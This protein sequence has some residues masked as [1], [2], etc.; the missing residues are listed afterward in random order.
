[1]SSDTPPS[2]SP[3]SASPAKNVGKVGYG[4]DEP[5]SIIELAIAGGL[6]VVIGFVISA[7][8][9]RINP[10][11]ARIGLLAGPAVGFLILA[12]AAALYW[13]SRQGKVNEMARIVAKIPWGGEEVVLE[14]G[15]GRGLGMV[16][17]TKRLTS[18]YAVGLDLWQKGHLSG[19]DPKSIWAN[20][21]QE[22]VQDKVFAVKADPMFLPFAGS[23]VDVVLS[24]VSIHRLIKHKD[25]GAAFSE[26]GR[27]LKNG[28]RVGILEA[29]NGAIY[30][31]L[32]KRQGMLDVSVHRLRFSSFPPFH[33]VMARKPF[34]G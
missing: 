15:C 7:Y 2:V 18:G 28:G 26:M 29:G 34:P 27:I 22:G 33:V 12:V 9:E 23:T 30:S 24:A 25:R 16:L 10:G 8:T 5:R 13:S 14:L 21:T 32:L 31:D 17:A 6:A 4:I 1:M 20:A 11:T 19:N 3:P